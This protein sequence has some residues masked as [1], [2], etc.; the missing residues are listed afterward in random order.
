LEEYGTAS[1]VT[2]D[3]IMR[4]RENANCLPDN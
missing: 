3:I 1:Q 2:D 4:R